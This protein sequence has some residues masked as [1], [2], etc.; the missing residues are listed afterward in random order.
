MN[1]STEKN[2]KLGLLIVLI[3]FFCVATFNDLSISKAIASESNLFG[4]VMEAIT[5]V[6]FV[7][8]LL[9]SG[10]IAIGTCKKG[11]SSKEIIIMALCGLYYL[12]AILASSVMIYVYLPNWML[13]FHLIGVVLLTRF[14]F[15]IDES[16]KKDWQKFALVCGLVFI[17]STLV[18]ETIKP[19]WGRVRPRSIDGRDE[20]FTTWFTVNGS[21]FLSFVSSKE[22]IK[23]FPSGHSQWG[24]V[25]L[26][27][28]MIPM[29]SK[30]FRGQ[31]FKFLLVCL[32]WS[33]LVMSGR[34]LVAAH[35]PTD[36]MIGFTITGCIFLG[37]RRLV[38]GKK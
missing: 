14:A 9:I 12:L 3:C 38:F 13:F 7:Y 23:S 28:S 30:K 1:K 5:A 36:T 26:C 25:A 27:F 15:N 8:V 10:C 16:E 20:L 31:D 2:V 33:L 4:Q 29:I 24:A 35:F 34:I 17:G 6:P 18:I 19:V 37:V 32:F 11:K 21:K 22:E